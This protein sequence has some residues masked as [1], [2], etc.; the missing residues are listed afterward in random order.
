MEALEALA[1]KIAVTD[2]LQ[3]IVRTM[4]TLSAVSIRQYERAVTALRQYSGTIELGLHV[5]LG[6]EPNLIP[7]GP[8]PAGPTLAIVFGSDHG[9]CGR[10]ND[11]VVDYAGDRL[12]DLGVAPQDRFWLA[13]GIR[14]GRRLESQNERIE[15]RFSLPSTVSGLTGMA[16]NIL[17][18]VDEC[19]TSIGIERT[20]LFYNHRSAE[21]AASPQREQLL[22]LDPEKLGRIVK[23]PWPSRRLP[24]F[25]MKAP[26]LFSSLIRQQLFIAV[27]RAGA[28]SLA[29]EHASRLASMQAAEQNIGERLEEMKARYRHVRQESITEEL[30][31]IVAGFETLSQEK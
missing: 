6:H 4:K 5:I 7:E 13:V 30:L 12:N 31:D 11:E 19:R 26:E 24:T 2:D 18:K 21:A 10:F 27:F 22:P 1:K 17:I 14:A 3:S 8:K 25:T 29:S 15:G 9:L 28:E 16:H 23:E 20:L